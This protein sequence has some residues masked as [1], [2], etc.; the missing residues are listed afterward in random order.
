MKEL[1]LIFYKPKDV[2]RKIK[3]NEFKWGFILIIIILLTFIIKILALPYVQQIIEHTKSFTQIP[4]DEAKTFLAIQQ[5]MRYF[6]IIMS[7]ISLI[8]RMF[9]YSLII[10]VG[11]SL[12]KYKPIFKQIFSLFISSYL[13]I[14]LGEVMNIGVL[15]LTKNNI[16]SQYDMYLI[17]LNILFDIEKIGETYFTA[18]Y[19]INPFQI[20]FII[21]LVKG[22]NNIIEMK[23]SHSIIVTLAMW[24]IMI[25]VPIGLTYLNQ[26]T[27][28]K[29]GV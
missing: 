11:V 23:I 19:Y 22:L 1:A 24:F 21:F 12:F 6:G 3:L 9:I 15:L 29:V 2:F 18:L 14:T 25:F 28:S 7:I 8:I 27:L 20:W 16:V 10:W 4:Q 17:G 26:L 5:K 13:I